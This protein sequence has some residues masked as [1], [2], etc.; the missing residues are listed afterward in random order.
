MPFGGEDNHGHLVRTMVGVNQ[1][2]KGGCEEPG[3]VGFLH[4]LKFGKGLLTSTIIL[5]S[6]GGH[7][8][9]QKANYQRNTVYPNTTSPV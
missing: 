2:L 5:I 3:S 6:Y 7:N 8:K 1:R 4:F 9:P